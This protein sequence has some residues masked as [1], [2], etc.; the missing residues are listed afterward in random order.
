MSMFSC[1]T[2]RPSL[3]YR[4]SDVNGHTVIPPGVQFILLDKNT[5][6]CNNV[7]A[8]FVCVPFVF[9]CSHGAKPL[10]DLTVPLANAMETQN[11]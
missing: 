7:E 10:N 1:G 2:A 11:I 8:Y 6:L 9:S 3:S 4:Y 5:A